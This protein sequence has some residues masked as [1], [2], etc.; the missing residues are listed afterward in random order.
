MAIIRNLKL[1]AKY[2]DFRQFSKDFDSFQLARKK[3]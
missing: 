3:D 2:G 1:H